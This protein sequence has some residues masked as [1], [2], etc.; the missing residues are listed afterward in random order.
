MRDRVGHPEF[1]RRKQLE[2]ALER[3]YPGTFVPRYS[4][5]SF[6]RIPYSIAQSRGEIQD[7]ILEELGQPGAIDWSRA[8]DLINARLTPL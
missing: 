6:H 4:M 7:R 3:R 8:D 1:L 2:Q 5:V